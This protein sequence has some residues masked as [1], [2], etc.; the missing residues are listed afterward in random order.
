MVNIKFSVIKNLIKKIVTKVENDELDL[1]YNYDFITFD[2][3]KLN[4]NDEKINPK[5]NP[6]ITVKASEKVVF[7][8]PNCD[9]ITTANYDTLR[10]HIYCINPTCE[11]FLPSKKYGLY[12]IRRIC[13]ERKQTLLSDEYKNVY[14][15]LQLQCQNCNI[16][17]EKTFK[18]F[19]EKG[20]CSNYDCKYERAFIRNDEIYFKPN[21]ESEKNINYKGIIAKEGYTLVNNDIIKTENDMV[22]IKCPLGHIFESNM[23]IFK[24][25][26]S[27]KRNKLFCE[28]CEEKLKQIKRNL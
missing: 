6:D 3:A 19:M 24:N 28:I 23:S 7:Q 14:A 13:D 11:Y 20:A 4:I 5:L 18:E 9:I 15:P 2:N 26:Q 27:G 25:C 21:R 8:C 22:K 17:H 1:E 16:I 12:D 10:T